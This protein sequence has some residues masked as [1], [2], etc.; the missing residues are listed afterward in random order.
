MLTAALPAQ[1]RL[2]ALAVQYAIGAAF[3]LPWAVHR[4]MVRRPLR[5]LV[6]MTVAGFGIL[7]LPQVLIGLSVGKLSPAIPLAALAT[8]PVLLAVGG[9]LTISTAVCG[10][11]GVL[12]LVDDGLEIS[13]HQSP[14][15]L[16]L[17][18]AACVLAW[19]LAAAE[20][21]LRA[22][23]H[24]EVLFTQCA[25]S[26][27]LLFILSQLIGR[28]PLTWS[29]LA[30]IGFAVNA[31]VMTVFGYLLFYWLLRRYG[32]GR[33]SILQWSQPLVATAEAAVL[34][35]ARPD[36]T[37]LVGA[38][39]IAIAIMLAFSNRDEAGGVLFEI[40]RR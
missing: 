32:A 19:A 37:A 31:G 35:H 36:W 9:R 14:W 33:V 26:A 34:M 8:V 40:T 15:L 39:L 4:R 5:S 38:L 27:V 12:F 18:A 17:L 21:D 30:G 2:R 24:V 29:A 6:H 11:A 20:K 10:L 13:I 23:S 1:P 7:C 16:L 25:T 28:E 22:I 3:L